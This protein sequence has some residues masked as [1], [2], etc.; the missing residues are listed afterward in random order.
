MSA[1]DTTP[2]AVYAVTERGEKS[3]WTRIGAAFTNADGSIT[4][5]LDATPVSGILVI[6]VE[7]PTQKEGV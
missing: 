6:R 5:R 3:Y 7:K 1:P 4:V 2:R